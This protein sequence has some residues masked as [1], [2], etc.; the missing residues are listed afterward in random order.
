MRE[1]ARSTLNASGVPTGYA[2]NSGNCWRANLSIQARR[3]FS[4]FRTLAGTQTKMPVGT[5]FNIIG[6]EMRPR[7]QR[8]L[9]A[10][11]P[12]IREGV[13]YDRVV[14]SVDLVP[15]L[16]VMFGFSPS[17]AQGKSISELV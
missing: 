6:L 15:T 17:F 4:F 2:Q 11:G 7:V 5:A 10:I 12:G 13:I 8:G 16:G 14:E 1:H 3:L 9:M